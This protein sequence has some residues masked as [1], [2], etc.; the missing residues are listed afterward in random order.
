MNRETQTITTPVSKQE[1]V[2][3]TYLTGREKRQLQNVFLQGDLAFNPDSKNVTG[4]NFSLIDKEQDLAWSLVVVS[5]DGSKEDVVTKI[6]DMRAEDYDFIVANV[7][8]I[9]K[10]KN[11]EEKKTI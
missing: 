11:F 1:V 8:A 4:I 9:R 6:L 2:I 10:D 7:N 5:I 3:N